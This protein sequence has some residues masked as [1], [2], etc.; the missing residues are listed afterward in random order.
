MTQLEYRAME[1]R[2]RVALKE[3]V[4]KANEAL[5]RFK[6]VDMQEAHE[7]VEDMD[8]I[9]DRIESIGE[10]HKYFYTGINKDVNCNIEE[11]MDELQEGYIQDALAYY[12]EDDNYE[13]RSDLVTRIKQLNEDARKKEKV[14]N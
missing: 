6:N 7:N 4:L 11:L 8:F 13:I 1:R 2:V 5:D 9:I 12:G 3:I 10:R 14:T